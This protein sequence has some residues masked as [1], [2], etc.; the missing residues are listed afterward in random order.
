MKF[1]NCTDLSEE[2]AMMKRGMIHLQRCDSEAS[3]CALIMKSIVTS[4][5]EERIL[6]IT[7]V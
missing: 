5:C 2:T 1:Q 7:C 6:I 3:K 4:S